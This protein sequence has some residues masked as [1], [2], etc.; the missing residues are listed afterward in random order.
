MLNPDT[1]LPSLQ[2]KDDHDCVLLTNYPLTLRNNL[3]EMPIDNA[4]LIWF[5][6]GS[7]LRDELG[8][9]CAGYAITSSVD[10]LENSYLPAIKTAELAE[11]I[12]LTS[13]CH[14]SKDLTDKIYTDS[15]YALGVAHDF[16]MVWK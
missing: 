4:G 3:R 15:Q 9:Y 2:D 1:L 6:D 8:H 12:A 11:L 5:K 14:L 13:A 7:S 10:V 16:G